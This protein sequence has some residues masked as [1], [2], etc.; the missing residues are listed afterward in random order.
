MGEPESS[1]DV[2]RRLLFACGG[3]M[4][5]RRSAYE[6]L[7]GFDADYFAYFED[8]DLGWRLN[9]LGHDVWY[10]PRATAFH[11]H[12][13]TGSRL[14]YAKLRVLY[15]RNALF[16][17]YKCLDEANLAAALPAAMLLLNERALLLAG[18]DPAEFR[19]YPPAESTHTMGGEP[20]VQRLYAY[21]P[22]Q[23]LAES[24]PARARRALSEEG[25]RPAL[26]KTNRY[27]R[28]RAEAAARRLVRLPGSKVVPAVAASHYVAL[29]E[30]GHSLEKLNLKRTWLQQRRRRSDAELLP[31]LYDPFHVNYRHP[32]YERFHDW[33][34]RV[35]GLDRRFS[36]VPD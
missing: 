4:L 19:L 25:L 36:T 6:E 27:L 35:Q 32:R 8:V 17:I 22:A 13:A 29:S 10:T 28:Q 16:T 3:A 15:E 30:F 2:E 33:M 5:I 7:G 26:G 11:R 31:L 14:P 9:L 21:D 20:L 23:A 18:L 24:L 34:V 1:H 12:H